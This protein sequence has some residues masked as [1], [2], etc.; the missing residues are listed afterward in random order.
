MAED[1]ERRAPADGHQQGGGVALAD[2]DGEV[3]ARGIP[4]QAYV[5]AAAAAM[6]QLARAGTGR[7]GGDGVHDCSSVERSR[8]RTAPR[9]LVRAGR[10]RGGA[11]PRP[12]MD[13]PA[14]G[15][16]DNPTPSNVVTTCRPP[17]RPTHSPLS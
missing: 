11:N 1:V 10:G 7:V 4:D 13:H 8:G 14:G 17:V 9:R 16:A 15:G 2:L 5:D 12:D 6:G 3:V